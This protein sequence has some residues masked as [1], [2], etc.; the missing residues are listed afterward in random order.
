MAAP[1]ARPYD[2]VSLNLNGRAVRVEARDDMLLLRPCATSWA[3]AKF[4]LGTWIKSRP[5][6]SAANRQSFWS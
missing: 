6:S 4:D 1:A 2:S 3:A 5:K